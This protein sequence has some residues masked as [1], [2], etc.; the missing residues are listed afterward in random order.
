LDRVPNLVAMVS[1]NSRHFEGSHAGKVAHVWL[2]FWIIK[3]VA[4]TL[5]ETGG[6]ALS[7]P[8]IELGYQTAT[9]IFLAFFAV[10][11]VGQVAAKKYHPALYWAVIVATTTLGTTTADWVTRDLHAFGLEGLGY[12][13][14]SLAIFVLLILVLAVWKLATGSI[15]VNRITTKKSE[16]FYWIAILV[17]NTLGTALGDWLSD[18][19]SV[20]FGGGALLFGATIAVIGALYLFT[21]ISRPILF[22]SAFILTRP[23][24]AT[25][26]DLVTKP[27]AQGGLNL[28]RPVSSLIILALMIPMIYFWSRSP[29]TPE[30]AA[31]T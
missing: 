30:P 20:G 28:S 21:Q 2:G 23:L 26:G 16:V 3:V 29:E 12:S 4:T 15:A 14:A 17:S 11:L 1:M 10:T 24:G 18:S 8:P 7:M 6:D 9:A 22:W 19:E 27:N 5:G 31:T 13:R 25:L